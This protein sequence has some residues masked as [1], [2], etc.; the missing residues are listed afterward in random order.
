M[1]RACDIYGRFT[2]RR[3]GFNWTVF[4][5]GSDDIERPFSGVK[6]WRRKSAALVAQAA[7]VEV[8][9]AYD[10]SRKLI[11]DA[12]QVEVQKWDEAIAFHD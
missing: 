12:L 9:N 10:I 1:T 3:A 5:R 2:V 7:N 6:F 11:L 8:H 4:V